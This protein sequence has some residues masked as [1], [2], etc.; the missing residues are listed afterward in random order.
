MVVQKRQKLP[1]QPA[2][3]LV[4]LEQDGFSQN[5]KTSFHTTF[6]SVTSQLNGLSY[7]D[8]PADQTSPVTAR[9]TEHVLR[10]LDAPK[11]AQA[12]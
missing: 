10:K 2:Q 4:Q 11:T 1:S 9:A 12:A 7:T 8:S 6:L 3:T 5:F